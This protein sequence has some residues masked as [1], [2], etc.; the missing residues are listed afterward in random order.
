MRIVSVKLEPCAVDDDRALGKLQRLGRRAGSIAETNPR[1]RA[2]EEVRKSL[3]PVIERM[4][5]KKK[6]TQR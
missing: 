3:L 6:T 1:S 4:R 2:W 5:E